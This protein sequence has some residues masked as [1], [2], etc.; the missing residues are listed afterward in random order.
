MPDEPEKKDLMVLVTRLE[1]EWQKLKE[2][3][4]SRQTESASSETLDSSGPSQQ[5]SLADEMPTFDEAPTDELDPGSQSEIKKPITM[6]TITPMEAETIAHRLAKVHRDVEVLDRLAKL[7]KQNRRITVIGSMFCTMLVLAMAIFA[8]LM[9]QP[10]IWSKTNLQVVQQDM[11]STK[12]SDPKVEPGIPP[13]S[14][15]AESPV[16][17]VGSATSNKYHYPDC[18]WARKIAPGRLVTFKS[19]EEAKGEG[20]IPCPACKPPNSD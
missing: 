1:H 4:R 3:L 12:P 15:E 5:E 6:G 17:Y 19:A 9:A 14:A 10:Q 8:Y 11:A 20:Y 18:K 2:L 7:E 16:K 13:Q